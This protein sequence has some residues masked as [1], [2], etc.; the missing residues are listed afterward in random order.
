ML[1]FYIM[2]IRLKQY[3]FLTLIWIYVTITH[4]GE[5]MDKDALIEIIKNLPSFLLNDKLIQDIIKMFINKCDNDLGK[6]NV[7]VREDVIEGLNIIGEVSYFRGKNLVCVNYFNGNGM[8]SFNVKE[9]G[10]DEYEVKYVEVYT[11][12]VVRTIIVNKKKNFSVVE[13]I[14][15]KSL[16]SSYEYYNYDVKYYDKNYKFIPLDYDKLIDEHY[17]WLFGISVREAKIKRLNFK[18]YALELSKRKAKTEMEAQFDMLDANA[19][20]KF[21]TPFCL[22]DLPNFIN[23]E[24]DREAE[25]KDEL[26]EDSIH[27]I[28]EVT[29]TEIEDEVEKNNIDFT[30]MKKI[31]QE[32]VKLIGLDGE[33]VISDNLFSDIVLFLLGLTVDAIFSKGLIIKKIDGRYTLY[34]VMIENDKVMVIP[35]E[36]TPEVAEDYFYRCK[37]NLDVDGL[38]NFFGG[39]RGL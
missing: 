8:I 35:R 25:E 3:L 18:K 6:I 36:I 30:P 11:D 27:E 10:N 15:E 12:S 1:I 24:L 32:L 26:F 23:E 22:G 28:M 37:D 7:T 5:I 34:M 13:I 14:D 17:A 19:L 2:S 29:G 33:V 31:Y 16:M 4:T 21:R 38:D 20:Y 9:Q 39:S